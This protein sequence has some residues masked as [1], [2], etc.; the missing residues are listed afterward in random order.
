MPYATA[1]SETPGPAKFW[2]DGVDMAKPELHHSS[3]ISYETAG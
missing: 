1:R 2:N 3:R